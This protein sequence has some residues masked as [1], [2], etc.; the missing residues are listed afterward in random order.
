MT[1]LTGLTLVECPRDAM[2]GIKTLIPTQVKIDYLTHLLGLGFDV[3]DCGSFVNPKSIPQMADTAEVIQAISGVQS[4]TKLLVIV[5]NERG[6]TSALAFPKIRYLGFPF[7]LSE[8]FQRKNTNSS[9]SG[10]FKRLGQIQSIAEVSGKEVVAYLSMAFG[11]PYKD[12]W[13]TEEVTEWAEKIASLG[14]RTI[15]LADT[16]GHADPETVSYLFEHLQQR[17]P[18]IEIGVHLHAKVEDWLP[19]VNAAYN[20]GC[21]R[22]DGALGGVGGCPLAKDELVGNLPSERVFNWLLDRNTSNLK[23]DINW[24]ECRLLALRTYQGIGI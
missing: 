20:S 13:N 16:L 10:A 14:I 9:R 2:Q 8:T 5:A 12:P 1:K 22:F 6:A 3:L 24:E 23:I 7:S 18:N 19:K 21:R 15:S 4:K 17:L 11:N